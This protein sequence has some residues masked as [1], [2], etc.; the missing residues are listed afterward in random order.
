MCLTSKCVLLY[1]Y[2]ISTHVACTHVCCFLSQ[3]NTAVHFAARSGSTLVLTLLRNAGANSAV[4]CRVLQCVAVVCS[5]LQ[6]VAVSCSVLQCLAVSDSVL[7]SVAVSCSVLQ[8]IVYCATGQS[9]S[10][11]AGIHICAFLNVWVYM[12]MLPLDQHPAGNIAI[13]LCVM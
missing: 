1:I 4:R 8:C 13:F 5:V 10:C 11:V 2:Y 9:L 6:C 7:Q 12:Q 3:G